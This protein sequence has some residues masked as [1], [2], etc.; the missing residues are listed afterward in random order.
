MYQTVRNAGISHQCIRR[1]VAHTLNSVHKGDRNLSVHLIGDKKMR[2]L[3]RQYRGKD[4]TTDVLSFGLENGFDMVKNKE[5][6]D[7]FISIP[8]IQRQAKVYKVPFR[9]ECVRMLIHGVLHLL[10]YDHV[11]PREAKPMFALQEKV[12]SEVL[13]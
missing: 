13:S 7:I 3:N 4:K 10:G 6:G 8:Q 1:T 11:V 2:R 9:E 12:L 5:I